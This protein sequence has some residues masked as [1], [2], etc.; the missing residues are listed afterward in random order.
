M[1]REFVDMGRVLWGLPSLDRLQCQAECDEYNRRCD[2]IVA[3]QIAA[4][5]PA[6]RMSIPVKKEPSWWTP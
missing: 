5:V 1:I 3:A 4:G 2:E 6:N